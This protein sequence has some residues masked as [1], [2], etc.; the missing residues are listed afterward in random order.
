MA[1]GT[2]IKTLQE[3]SMSMSVKLK[4][5]KVAEAEL[6]SFVHNLTVPPQLVAD[7]F[8]ADVNES[9]LGYLVALRSKL[10]FCSTD[11]LVKKAAAL[12]DVEPELERCVR[13]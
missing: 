1:H 2:Q 5:R 12:Q 10:A 7:V 6:G 4:N 8:D 13:D 3:Q 9:Y 11:P